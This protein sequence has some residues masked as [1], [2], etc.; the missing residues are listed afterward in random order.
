MNLNGAA[1]RQ[2]LFPAD[3]ATTYDYYADLENV[4]RYLRY[5]EID[6]QDRNDE[7]LY[8][9]AYRTREMGAYDVCVYC[10]VM[11]AGN[12]EQTELRMTPLTPKQSPFPRYKPQLDS[13]KTVAGGDFSLVSALKSRPDGQTQIRMDLSLTSKIEVPA[14]MRLIMTPIMGMVEPMI[15]GRMDEVVDTFVRESVANYQR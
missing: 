15:S 9:L 14:M 12:A 10:D 6:Q 8:R 2:F 4:V 3:I 5:V 7:R 11:Y 1:Q 13:Q